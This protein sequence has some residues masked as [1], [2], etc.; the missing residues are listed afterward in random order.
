MSTAKRSVI[1]RVVSALTGRWALLLELIF[2]GLI[3]WSI[4]A[5]RHPIAG[6]V[7]AVSQGDGAEVRRIIEGYGALAPLVSVGLIL[8]HTVI[9]LPA[10]LLTL[11]NGLA[12]GFWKGLAITWSAFML[13]ASIL[14]A[15]GRFW[16]RPLLE[17]TIPERHQRRLDEWLQREGAFPLLTVRLIPLV[18][19]NAVGLAAGAVRSPLRTYLWTTGVG[20]LP[21]GIIVTFLGSR[22][23]ERHT[24]P[25][26]AFWGLSAAL[27]AIV[28]TAWFVGHRRRSGGRWDT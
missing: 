9:P 22:L 19:F 21:L 10:E 11:A 8:L 5:V 26:V 4:P 23:G 13:S 25:G 16:G 27:L 17:R 7:G 6:L 28:L 3:L 15:A 18:P 20:I 2:L 14:Y 24:H 1:L 12:F